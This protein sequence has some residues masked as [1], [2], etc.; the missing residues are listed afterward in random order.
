MKADDFNVLMFDAAYPPPITGGKEK[1]AHLLARALHERGIHVQALSYFH[2]GNRTGDHD[3]IHVDRVAKGALAPIRLLFLLARLRSRFNVLHIHTPS[4]IGRS[5]AL[6]GRLCGFRVV[7]KF[8]SVQMLEGLSRTEEFSWRLVLR[9]CGTLVVL[10]Q[11]AV[12]ELQARGVPPEKIFHVSN[13]VDVPDLIDMRRE[14]SQV[15]LL[16]VGRLI[17]LKRC[18]DILQACASLPGALPWRLTVAGDGPERVSLA[19]LAGQLQ[20]ADRVDFIGHHDK[21]LELMKQADILVLASTREGMPN[22]VLEA[23]SV[24]LPVVST[25]VGAVPDM[26]GAAAADYTFPVKNVAALSGRIERL[27]SE[28]EERRRYG[29]ALRA[30]CEERYS[31]GAVA[32]HYIERY[33]QISA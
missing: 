32:N 17:E 27:V 15:R 8:P 26:L 33:R 10:A 24:G 3:G 4:R 12:D 14:D 18:R 25:P 5:L 9:A 11:Q 7:F 20:I 19:D 16:F 2:N 23:M 28:P 13:G 22:V 6:M 29:A 31:I 30:R 21:P 1:Q